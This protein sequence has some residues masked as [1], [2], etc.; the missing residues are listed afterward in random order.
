MHLSIA[1]ILLHVVRR[2]YAILNLRPVVWLG[3]ISYSLYLWQQLFVFGT[4]PRPWYLVF[5]ALAM[6]SASYYLIEQPM[7]R[8]RERRAEMWKAREAYARAA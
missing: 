7:L 2:P 1:G 4:H 3:T 8:L 6:A 5:F